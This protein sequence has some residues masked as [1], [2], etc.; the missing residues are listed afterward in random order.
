MG[1]LRM[2]RMSG[3]LAFCGLAAVVM[4]AIGFWRVMQEREVHSRSIDHERTFLAVR[5]ANALGDELTRC[6]R[7]LSQAVMPPEATACMGTDAP[8]WAAFL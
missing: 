5:A 4:F 7:L 2:R 8:H 1:S 6:Q 3:L